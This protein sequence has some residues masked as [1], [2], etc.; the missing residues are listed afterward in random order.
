MLSF[1]YPPEAPGADA[2]LRSCLVPSVFFSFPTPFCFRSPGEKKTREE[3]AG[4]EGGDR[5]AT[6]LD[7]GT[8]KEQRQG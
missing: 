7:G 1:Y 2:A 4:G 8:E 6:I 5:M 3:G